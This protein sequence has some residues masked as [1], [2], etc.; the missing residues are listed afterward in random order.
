MRPA[1]KIVLA[2]A[3]FGLIHSLLASRAVKAKVAAR[4]GERNRNGLYRAA[5]N[6]QAIAS[7]ALLI[8]YCKRLPD[9]QL[10]QVRGCPAALL[11][12]TRVALLI[13]MGQAVRQ[14]GVLRMGGLTNLAAVVQG[15]RAIAPEPEAQG[16]A[17]DPDHPVKGPFKCTRHPLNFLAVPLVWLTPRMTRNRLV[18]NCAA[19]LYFLIGSLH[20]EARLRRAHPAE[21][22]DYQRRVRFLF[23]R[24]PKATNRVLQ[25]NMAARASTAPLADLPN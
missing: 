17:L 13:G 14:V 22:R 1:T 15:S 23:G 19:T 4:V 2:V 8:R 21:Y 12:C 7:T 16:P 3:A 24:K 20:E 10:W 18:F 6:A 11:H 9:R 5:Y 25:P